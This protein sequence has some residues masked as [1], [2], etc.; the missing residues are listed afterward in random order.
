MRNESDHRSCK[1]RR[2]PFSEIGRLLAV[3]LP[4]TLG[5]DSTSS[6]RLH[7]QL[8]TTW[9]SLAC[10]IDRMNGEA[11]P[12]R[13]LDSGPDFGTD[14][15]SPGWVRLRAGVYHSANRN[16][17]RKPVRVTESDLESLTEQGALEL[18]RINRQWDTSGKIPENAVSQLQA[19][20]DLLKIAAWPADQPPDSKRSRVIA[21][22]VD[23][24]SKPF[25]DAQAENNQDQLNALNAVA[26]R[27]LDERVRLQLALA[28]RSVGRKNISAALAAVIGAAN[29]LDRK[30]IELYWE[31]VRSYKTGRVR[32][33]EAV[34]WLGEATETLELEGWD[35]REKAL[36]PVASLQQ[37]FKT[38]VIQGVTVTRREWTNIVYDSILEAFRSQI[39]TLESQQDD[40]F[41]IIDQ[42]AQMR[43]VELRLT[44]PSSAAKRKA[45]KHLDDIHAWAKRGHV[46]GKKY[47]EAELQEALNAISDGHVDKALE[48]IAAAR[49]VLRDSRLPEIERIRTIDHQRATALLDQIRHEHQWADDVRERAVPAPGRPPR[50][51]ALQKAADRRRHGPEPY[52]THT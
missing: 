33:F 28:E 23:A 52:C 17:V 43:H 29:T 32:K 24:I 7:S 49:K 27:L 10:R 41:D 22:E 35:I 4:L 40:L 51:I 45:L 18:L 8:L 31:R 48:R 47:A 12:P 39:H 9:P 14:E 19:V 26:Q 11:L 1:A 36:G 30:H 21:R 50:G 20:R 37:R 3:A 46:K 15:P 34:D 42:G 2:A 16:D 38:R 5:L 44:R 13:A 6:N 25:R